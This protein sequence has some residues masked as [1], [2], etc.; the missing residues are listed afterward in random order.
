VRLPPVV[1]LGQTLLQVLG[2]NREVKATVNDEQVTI[3]V[4]TQT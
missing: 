4:E 2:D 1:D 3:T